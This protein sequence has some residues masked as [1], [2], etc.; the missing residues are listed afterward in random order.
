MT[1]FPEV[2]ATP[3]AWRQ[4]VKMLGEQLPRRHIPVYFAQRYALLF[5]AFLH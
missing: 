3:G 4:P 1:N 5:S 2:A